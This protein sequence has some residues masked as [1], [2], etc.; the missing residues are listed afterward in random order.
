MRRR[1]TAPAPP[2]E[3]FASRRKAPAADQKW[4]VP[5]K[6]R[7]AA[8]CAP[9]FR[10]NFDSNLGCV[11]IAPRI[12]RIVTLIERHRQRRIVAVYRPL[13]IRPDGEDTVDRTVVRRA[14]EPPQV[15]QT[16]S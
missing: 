1:T 16:V 4:L 11:V 5:T 10:G 9:T 13:R 7:G 12:V 15:T 3:S 6:H 14:G 2:R 8:C